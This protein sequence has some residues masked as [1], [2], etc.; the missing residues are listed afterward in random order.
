MDCMDEHAIFDYLASKLGV[1]LGTS[2]SKN[3]DNTCCSRCNKKLKQN[4]AFQCSRCKFV[5]YCKRVRLS[6]ALLQRLPEA[7]F[8]CF[9]FNTRW[10][11]LPGIIVCHFVSVN[12]CQ[13]SANVCFN[14]VKDWKNHKASCQCHGLL[15]QNKGIIVE[16]HN[17]ANLLSAINDVVGKRGPAKLDFEIR[18]DVASTNPHGVDFVKHT[19]MSDKIL[20]TSIGKKGEIVTLDN[21][22][23]MLETLAETDDFKIEYAIQLMEAVKGLIGMRGPVYFDH[24][25]VEAS[26]MASEVSSFCSQ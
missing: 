18:E 5:K 7:H 20:K 4:K 19:T 25:I 17:Y 10:K 13:H 22:S 12:Y 24:G 14:Q 11:R 23:E 21:V 2:P 16:I 3:C 1:P 26:N 6:I 8:V 9:L 15:H